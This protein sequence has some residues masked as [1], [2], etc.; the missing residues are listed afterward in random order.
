[1]A[2]PKNL[3]S[4]L[5]ELESQN[6]DAL[7]RLSDPIDTRYEITALQRKLDQAGVTQSSWWRS[8][9]GFEGKVCDYPL[10]TNLTASRTLCASI[11]GIDPRKVASSYYAR[12]KK[13]LDPV[14][15][16]PSEAP[17]K[18]VI[19]KENINL[20]KFPVTIHTDMDPGPYIGTSFVTTIDP[21]T[22]IDNIAL[23]R[24]W[25]KSPART[26]F[27]PALAGHNWNNMQK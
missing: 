7:L 16:T 22:G 25:V 18:E 26:G 4:F 10:V 14:V 3:H 12:M 23:Q 27:W 21:D 19:E 5:G 24:I 13:T 20:W 15:V 1:M 17:C 11:L 6:P 9:L 2:Q 8:Q